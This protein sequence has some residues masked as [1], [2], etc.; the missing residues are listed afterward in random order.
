[1]FELVGY[2]YVDMK[3][4]DGKMTGY[5][6]FFLDHNEQDGLVGAEAIKVFFRDTKFPCFEPSL[7]VRYDLRFNQKG[8]LIGYAVIDDNA[9]SAA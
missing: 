9:E 8:K 1:M 4:D 5:S 6:C 7:G 2:R 3:T